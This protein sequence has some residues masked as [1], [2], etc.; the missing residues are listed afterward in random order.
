METFSNF[1]DSSKL[2][3]ERGKWGGGQSRGHEGVRAIG[4][5]FSSR[6]YFSSTC[7]FLCNV[8]SYFLSQGILLLILL[9]LKPHFHKENILYS[10]VFLLYV[11]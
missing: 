2:D 4:M 9:H 10:V 8:C 3:G 11:F 7:F 6:N 1:S 5:F